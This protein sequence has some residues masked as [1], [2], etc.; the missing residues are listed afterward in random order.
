M[1]HIESEP[2]TQSPSE[3]FHLIHS[4]Q[5]DIPR[6]PA[7]DEEA[8]W[9]SDLASANPVWRDVAGG[10]FFVVGECRCGCRSIV[11]DKPTEPQ[12]PWLKER[13][14]LVA[15]MSV[16]IQFDGK[17]DVVSILL[18]HAGGSLS[19]LQVI[20]YNFPDPVPSSWTETSREVL[21]D[22]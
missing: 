16:A 6:R 21:V 17:S 1:V 22:E 7:T 14:G 2:F 13:Q 5:I 4:S 19:V 3:D 8:G 18:H 9:I 10:P 11:L 15:E 20:W 12:K